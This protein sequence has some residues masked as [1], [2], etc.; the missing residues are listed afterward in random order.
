LDQQNKKFNPWPYVVVAMLCSTGV[1]NFILYKSS[2]SVNTRALT[3]SP[4][5]DALVYDELK[6]KLKCG[7][8]EGV[9]FD[10]RLERSGDDTAHLVIIAGSVHSGPV[11][12]KAWN[13]TGKNIDLTANFAEDKNYTFQISDLGNEFSEGLW[14]FRFSGRNS[15]EWV[16][17]K[18]V[19]LSS[20]PFS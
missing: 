17:D 2:Q 16:W 4:Y 10:V 14:Q 8:S 7:R 11:N 15:C 5:E 19:T 18:S 9:S 12:V 3:K 6:E 20:R 1:I 13:A